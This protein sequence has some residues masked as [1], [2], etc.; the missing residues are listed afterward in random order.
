MIN[1]DVTKEE[2]DAL[3]DALELEEWE[4]LYSIQIPESSASHEGYKLK[5]TS[6]YVI[7][8]RTFGPDRALAMCYTFILLRLFWQ[9]GLEGDD[10]DAANL[11]MLP[12][13]LKAT[14]EEQLGHLWRVDFD[15][16]SAADAMNDPESQLYYNF[17]A[18]AYVKD[19]MFDIY[20]VPLIHQYRYPI[21]HPRRANEVISATNVTKKDVAVFTFYLNL[22]KEMKYPEAAAG[23]INY[24]NELAWKGYSARTVKITNVVIR[25]R[26]TDINRTDLKKHYY[27]ITYEFQA[28][29]EGWDSTSA[30]TDPETGQLPGDVS[31]DG[32]LQDP[33]DPRLIYP[34]GRP[35]HT[36]PSFDFHRLFPDD[37]YTTFQE[38]GEYEFPIST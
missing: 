6:H 19:T 4:R 16:I 12:T 38:R 11:D 5:K 23:F 2:M 35:I 30:I 10:R 3:I 18:S 36:C 29:N 27:T 20:G 13:G 8:C 7:R 25:P 17:A 26:F 21:D 22:I 37:D 9:Q 28:N 34:P 32:N 15:I 33:L 31:F 14:C 1:I 24:V